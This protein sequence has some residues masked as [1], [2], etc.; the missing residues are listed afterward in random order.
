MEPNTDI[1]YIEAL[2]AK[3]EV[4]TRLNEQGR[5]ASYVFTTDVGQT[6]DEN[7]RVDPEIYLPETIKN[8]IEASFSDPQYS[9]FSTIWQQLS[10]YQYVNYMDGSD[11]EIFNFAM[12]WLAVGLRVATREITFTDEKGKVID[13]IPEPFYQ[14]SL[15]AGDEDINAQLFNL[16]DTQ[17]ASALRLEFSANI[18]FTRINLVNT[19]RQ[20]FPTLAA[21]LKLQL[22]LQKTLV[23]VLQNY[24]RQTI[25]IRAFDDLFNHG[26]FV[27][28]L[29]DIDTNLPVELSGNA[30]LSLFDSIRC[31][32]LVPVCIYNGD[33]VKTGKG[34]FE[35][36]NNRIIKTDCPNPDTLVNLSTRGFFNNRKA[37]KSFRI[38]MYVY[39]GDHMDQVDD[40]DHVDDLSNI[41]N[42][43]IDDFAEVVFSFRRGSPGFNKFTVKFNFKSP[44]GL[45]LKRLNAHL[46]KYQ[47]AIPSKVQNRMINITQMFVIPGLAIHNDVFMFNITADPIHSLLR[48]YEYDTPWSQKKILSFGLILVGKVKFI[49]RPEIVDNNT[50]MAVENGK[51]TT[52]VKGDHTVKITITAQNIE[53]YNLAKFVIMRTMDHYVR[54]YDANYKIFNKMFPQPYVK[55]LTPLTNSGDEGTGTTSIRNI[56]LLKVVDPALWMPANYTRVAASNVN[57]QV[58]PI[59]ESEIENYRRRGRMVIKWPVYVEGLPEEKQTNPSINPR[60][61]NEIRVFYTTISDENPYIALVPNLGSN[62]ATHPYIPKCQKT[63]SGL[64]VRDDWTLFMPNSE[65]VKNVSRSGKKTLRLLSPGETGSVYGSLNTFI[66]EGVPVFRYGLLRSRSSFLHAVLF[67]T[68]QQEDEYQKV[69]TQPIAE[70]SVNVV[71]ERLPAFA[72]ACMQENPDMTAEEIAEVLGDQDAY[73][74]PLLHYRALEEM[75]GVNI[76]IASP[77]ESKELLLQPPNF[78][79]FYTR[80]RRRPL[81]GCIVV[82]RLP[83]PH[84]DNPDVFQCEILYVTQGSSSALFGDIVTQKLENALNKITRSIRVTPVCV[85]RPTEDGRVEAAQVFASEEVNPDAQFSAQTLS[86]FTAMYVDPHGKCRGLCV[87]LPNK[88]EVWLVTPPIEPISGPNIGDTLENTSIEATENSLEVRK[89]VSSGADARNYIIETLFPGSRIQYVPQEKQLVGFWAEFE[90]LDVYVPLEPSPWSNDYTPVRYISP[91]NSIVTESNTQ[92]LQRLQRVVTVSIQIM[93]RLYIL[94]EMKAEDFVVEHMTVGTPSKPMTTSGSS[95]LIPFDVVQNFDLLK[96]HFIKQFPTLFQ[97]GKLLCDSEKYFENLARRLL[98]YEK[99]IEKERLMTSTFMLPEGNTQRLTKFP[100]YLDWYYACHDDFTVHSKNQ[101]IF[102]STQR[103]NTEIEIQKTSIVQSTTRIEASFLSRKNPYVYIHS[104]KTFRALYLIQNVENGEVSR[105]ATIVSYW[106]QNKVNLGFHTPA[107]VPEASA[108]IVNVSELNIKDPNLSFVIKYQSG[109]YAALLRLNDN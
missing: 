5:L 29:V 83:I 80:M 41:E 78:R 67:A 55:P 2:K 40:L 13:T 93:K 104:S 92:K 58:K 61:N 82:A 4:V 108:T 10:A 70:E 87:R 62:S 20:F 85:T 63:P 24:T 16:I 12:I 97:K 6:E 96:K 31:S 98:N 56:K 22:Q 46:T 39:L 26:S 76:F 18:S 21:N 106:I 34:M 86:K 60:T 49:V 69:H 45:L 79:M 33:E 8:A 95:R 52:L 1:D 11:L 88:S 77:G 32:K 59:K 84:N 94:S 3:L 75:F 91:F 48:F 54:T 71:R 47:V 43:K 37:M 28:D 64:L 15:A 100:R 25:S 73:L 109:S 99:V 44:T 38:I 68:T 53:Q 90:G 27:F 107:I 30:Y 103:L 35:S 7:L 50:F 89:V 72:S 74:D 9:E 51:L 66:G 19:A 102:M 23:R 42:A 105:A 57:Q 36:V 14:L 101:Q 17:I 65:K 81:S